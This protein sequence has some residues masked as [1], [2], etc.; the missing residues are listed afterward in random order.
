MFR[1]FKNTSKRDL[2]ELT[3][4]A[5]M[6]LGAEF[7]EEGESALMILRNRQQEL[8]KLY[9]MA[10]SELER[11][12]YDLMLDYLNRYVSLAEKYGAE[13]ICAVFDLYIAVAMEN[14]EPEEILSAYD[15]IIA[16]YEQRANVDSVARFE[17][18][19]EYYKLSLS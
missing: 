16:Y 11:K 8:I 6:D 17:K 4:D 10:Y 13:I 12:N 9:Q 19:R 2:N 14:E 15:D 1:W 7:T 18:R 5:L 3:N